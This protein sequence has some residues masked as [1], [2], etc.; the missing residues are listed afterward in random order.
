MISLLFVLYAAELTPTPNRSYFPSFTKVA[1][2]AGI[3]ITYLTMLTIGVSADTQEY[4]QHAN[5][6]DHSRG[7]PGAVIMHDSH[8]KIDREKWYPDPYESKEPEKQQY[9]LESSTTFIINDNAEYKSVE[10][11]KHSKGPYAA[12][13]RSCVQEE[14]FEQHTTDILCHLIAE[15]FP[16][17]QE[18][19]ITSKSRGPVFIEQKRHRHTKTNY[20]CNTPCNDYQ[21]S[22]TGVNIPGCTRHDF[23][24]FDSFD[25]SGK[26]IQDRENRYVTDSIGE[27]PTTFEN[28]RI[29][30]I[31]SPHF[32]KTGKV[33]RNPKPPK[34]SPRVDLYYQES[35]RKVLLCPSVIIPSTLCQSEPDNLILTYSQD[36]SEL[37]HVQRYFVTCNIAGW[38]G[39]KEGKENLGKEKTKKIFK[40]KKQ[41]PDEDE[42]GNAVIFDGHACYN[43]VGDSTP[44]KLVGRRIEHSYFWKFVSPACSVRT[45]EWATYDE[46]W[47]DDDADGGT[48]QIIDCKIPWEHLAGTFGAPAGAIIGVLRVI[49]II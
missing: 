35:N 49:K 15:A 47:E 4:Q 32:V 14:N 31:V 27:M 28:I 44:S 8:A 11:K 16:D 29:P 43:T 34:F 3:T 45:G 6:V 22:S 36:C 40:R 12:L 20:S 38:P 33:Q 48:S 39:K 21:I 9:H 19:L 26:K 1:F 25:D 7:G 23:Y 42:N 2:V 17:D 10:G 13:V 30:K 24:E 5:A 41:D 46:I 37:E 18:K